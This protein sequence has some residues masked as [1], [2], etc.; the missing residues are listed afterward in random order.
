MARRPQKKKL[1]KKQ[2]K[3]QR[4]VDAAP[5]RTEDVAPQK[6]ARTTVD[7]PVGSTIMVADLARRSGRTSAEIVGALLGNGVIATVNDSVDRETVEIIGEE[8]GI[9]VI[10]EV[11]AAETTDADVESEL[12]PRPP[13]V[14]VMGHVDHG[15]TSLL[16]SIRQANVASSESGGITQHIGA[17]Q[18][19]WRGSD[20]NLPERRITFVDT[21]GHE[22]FS[23]LRAHGASIT[24]IVILVVAAD[25]GVKPQTKEALSHAR[26]ANVPVIVAINKMDKPGA[27]V[28]RVK[29]QLVEL[30]LNPEDWGGKTPVVPVSAKA[31][32]G[33]DD[34][35]D[36]VLLVA[37]LGELTARPDGLA[38]GVIIESHMQPGVG[39]VATV[40]VQR[41]ELR[42]G[43]MVV[44]GTAWGRVR[45]MEDEYGTRHLT[46]K[47]S[48]PVRVAGLSS[49]A[50]FGTQL[51]VM[52]SEKAA[53]AAAQ[54]A[55]DRSG[56]R[57][58][59]YEESD[60]TPHLSVVLKADVGG[61]VEAIRS[62]LAN[63]QPEGVEVR[64]IHDAVGDLTESDV[65]L[66]MASRHPLLL[67]FRTN[68]TAA[69][70]N[71]AKLNN[72]P[73]YSFQVIYELIEHVETQA[74]ALREPTVLRV[75]TGRLEILGV[76][77]TTKT[78]QIVGGRVEQG[79]VRTGAVATI[80]RD[81]EE[82]GTG[83]IRS[84]QRGQ[85]PADL[86]REGE[87][88]GLSLATTT[89][90][91]VGDVLVIHVDETQ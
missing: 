41:G 36:T 46:A 74:K 29:G 79:D 31:G 10:D 39:P 45:F 87:E 4:K 19:V 11:A 25:D 1:S 33:I 2:L 78:E 24:D 58:V 38:R 49:V 88:C 54:Q 57:F 30:G 69:A 15:K 64:L 76:F 91:A 14:T 77:R 85:T 48:T 7:V 56:A 28:D 60:E 47:P 51:A 18:V 84:V 26:A 80:M 35:L 82:V 34:L 5:K 66:A 44:A 3:A 50:V 8:L 9:R 67:A 53:R 13:V 55:A 83:T 17:Y 6:P 52:T 37:D 89:P 42:V 65:H 40:L 27:N 23:A 90:A 12:V 59:N 75:E 21:P 43:D 86:V 70:K 71:L 68:V 62:S 81:G 63:L 20:G 22:A 72:L 73:I 61:S 32:T 16:D